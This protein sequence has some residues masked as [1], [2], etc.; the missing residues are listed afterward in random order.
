MAQTPV[1]YLASLSGGVNDTLRAMGDLKNGA[2]VEEFNAFLDA[3]AA[4]YSG[5]ITLEDQYSPSTFKD[6]GSTG[7]LK[8]Q[9]PTVRAGSY[10][11]TVQRVE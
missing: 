2:S 3:G 6:A 4:R 8:F 1:V 7:L 10:N 9:M 5:L 11:L